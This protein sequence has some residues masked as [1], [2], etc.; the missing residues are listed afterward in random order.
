MLAV[1]LIA[2]VVGVTAVAAVIDHRTGHIPNWLTLPILVAAPVFHGLATGI[3]A[4]GTSLLA[5]IIVGIVPLL[6]FR[7]GGLGGGDV[8]LFMAIGAILGA[9]LGLRIELFSF[10]GGACFGLFLL[11]RR[12]QFRQALAGIGRSFM[13]PFSRRGA[14]CAALDLGTIRFGPVIFLA[15]VVTIAG[16]V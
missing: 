9:R 10:L 12:G 14:A 13:R 2:T 7:S 8:K 3:G 5:A 15:T 1:I 11:A 6:A 4:A 16:L